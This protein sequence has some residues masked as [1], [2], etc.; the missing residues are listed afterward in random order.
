MYLRKE[1]KVHMGSASAVDG[2]GDGDGAWVTVI[3]MLV[4]RERW[5]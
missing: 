5:V 2:D 1:G 3:G 4:L